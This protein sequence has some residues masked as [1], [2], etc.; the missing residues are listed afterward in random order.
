MVIMVTMKDLF[1]DRGKPDRAGLPDEPTFDLTL[2]KKA[3]GE[4][5]G[6]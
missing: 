1:S 4:E 2:L 5:V 6:E 3:L